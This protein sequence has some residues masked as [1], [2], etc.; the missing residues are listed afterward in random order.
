MRVMQNPMISQ[1]RPSHTTGFTLIELAITLAIVGVLAGAVLVPFVAQVAQR[2]TAATE[3]TLE[4]IKEALLGYATATGRLPCPASGTS[5]GVEV[6]DIATGGNIAN[7]KCEN[8]IGFLPA[9]TLGF[10]PVDSQ[11]FAIDGWGTAK[12]RVRYAVSNQTVNG[13]G[14]PVLNPFTRANGMR[15]ATAAALAGSPLLFVCASGAPSADPVVHCG[16]GAAGT[17]G[18]VTLTSNAPVVVWSVGANAATGGISVDEAQNN[19]TADR[20][21][22]SHP[23]TTVAG[24]EF[25]DIV[26]WVAVGNL[27]SRMV[28]GGQL[29]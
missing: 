6:F 19:F 21:F 22:V 20:T 16:P 8:F 7:G 12:N 1:S 10:T 29:P 2:N 14:G 13:P 23:V 18:S 25:D 27:V 4:Q 11:G 26:T 17:G 3:K 9:A 28:L 24:N 5:N 15:S